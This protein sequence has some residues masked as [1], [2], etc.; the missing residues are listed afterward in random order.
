MLRKAAIINLMTRERRTFVLR[1]L[2]AGKRYRMMTWLVVPRPIAFVSTTSPE[3][4]DNLA[5]FSY[6][7]LGGDSPSSLAFCP[8]SNR[9]GDPKDTLK[10]IELCK[11]FVVN[12]VT[13]EMAKGMIETSFAYPQGYEEWVV[14]GF[15]KEPSTH[16]TP[17]RVAESPV[18]FECR[19]HEV[20]RHGTGSGASAYVIG[21]VLVVHVA[22]RLV[23]EDGGIQDR[24]RPIARLGGREYLDTECGKVFELVRPKGPAES[25]VD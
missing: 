11:E 13:S 20:V 18:Q 17:P 6:F 22:A 14:S 3:G 2:D 7:M 23:D 24:F 1:D 12:L 5:P 10:N 4:H 15:T 8:T 19:L 25:S 16:V 21:E 9:D